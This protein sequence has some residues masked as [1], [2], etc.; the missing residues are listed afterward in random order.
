MKLKKFE[1]LFFFIGSVLLS[2]LLISL[3]KFSFS[4]ELNIFI[5]KYYFWLCIF[6]VIV[7]YSLLF[8]SKKFRNFFL[9]LGATINIIFILVYSHLLSVANSSYKEV[10]VQY[11]GNRTYLVN[12]Y[13]PGLIPLCSN[14]Y[15]IKKNYF[16]FSKNIYTIGC[17][18]YKILSATESKIKLLVIKKPIIKSHVTEYDTV[19]L[20]F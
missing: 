1:F 9:I 4:T 3:L 16:L 15:S 2:W 12:T 6:S 5:H 7:F 17:N 19:Y 11:F 18:D 8:C 20:D 13:N 10:R 14:T